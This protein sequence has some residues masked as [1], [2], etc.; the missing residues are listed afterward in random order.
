MVQH[1]TNKTVYTRR[2]GSQDPLGLA[3]TY[4]SNLQP[5]TQINSSTKPN[6][7]QFSSRFHC[8]KPLF[9]ARAVS[10][11]WN[12]SFL[13]ISCS[14]S[15]KFILKNLVSVSVFLAILLLNTQTFSIHHTPPLPLDLSLPLCFCCIL[16]IE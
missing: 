14:V 6:Y 3:V 5:V 11:I 2:H 16:D 12:D 10:D 9:F 7:W 4:N 1:C 15:A 8:F 13:Y